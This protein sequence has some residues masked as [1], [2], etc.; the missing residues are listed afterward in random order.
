MAF[1]QIIDSFDFASNN[2]KDLRFKI[3][4][5]EQLSNFFNNWHY[6]YIPNRGSK[7]FLKNQKFMAAF[8]DY[9]YYYL[10]IF[11]DELD[12]KRIFNSI[13]FLVNGKHIPFLN[14]DLLPGLNT[15]ELDNKTANR[16]FGK[17]L[18]QQK[19]PLISYLEFEDSKIDLKLMSLYKHK[20]VEVK[21]LPVEDEE[22]MIMRA[23]EKGEG[24][25]FGY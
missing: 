14:N 24:E 4:Y 5:A 23:L 7:D 3:F 12:L 1:L 10:F 19:K 20:V 16:L 11:E 8:H 17:I 2:I 9:A 18:F 22:N 6:F 13:K 25:K 21:N 15:T